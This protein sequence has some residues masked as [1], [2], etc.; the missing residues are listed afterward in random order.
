MK[1]SRTL[2]YRNLHWSVH[3]PLTDWRTLQDHA[4]KDLKK[5][6]KLKKIFSVCGCFR[7]GAV[8]D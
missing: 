8:S 3:A 5:K 6:N 1:Q 4:S 7:A 2:A